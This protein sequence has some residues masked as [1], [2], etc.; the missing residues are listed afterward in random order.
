[1]GE[2][3]REIQWDKGTWKLNFDILRAE[4]PVVVVVSEGRVLCAPLPA[5]GETKIVTHQGEVK[6][7]KWDEWEEF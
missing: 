4:E 5:H 1:M 7:V 3:M 6:R 2:C